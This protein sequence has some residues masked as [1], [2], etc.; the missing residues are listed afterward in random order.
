MLPHVN[1]AIEFATLF[2]VSF[3]ARHEPAQTIQ[4][5]RDKGTADSVTAVT[6]TS[7]RRHICEL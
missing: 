1:D 3:T 2:D 5:F 4:K 6:A 7:N